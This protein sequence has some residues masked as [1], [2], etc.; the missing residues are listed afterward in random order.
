[1]QPPQYTHPPGR[2][3]LGEHPRRAANRS[4]RNETYSLSEPC[5]SGHTPYFTRTLPTPLLVLGEFAGFKV[6]CSSATPSRLVLVPVLHLS[7][8]HHQLN[9]K[10]LERVGGSSGGVEPASGVD[11]HCT[12]ARMHACMALHA[13]TWTK[14]RGK[15]LAHIRTLASRHR[16]SRAT[17]CVPVDRHSWAQATHLVPSQHSAL[18]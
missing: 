16:R 9:L 4:P 7:D 11:F 3:P 15:A 1:M 12:H 2:H 14:L 5:A 8:L 10:S 17:P 6:T 18:P 13:D